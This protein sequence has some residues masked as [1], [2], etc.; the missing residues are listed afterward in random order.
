MADCNTP[1][2][3][4]CAPGPF[5]SPVCYTVP[6]SGV[7]FDGV[8]RVTIN[9]DCSVATQQILDLALA[10]VPGAVQA[11]CDPFA[12][13]TC[14]DP[15][16]ICAIVQTL[17]LQVP[18]VG[19][20][21]L[22]VT[23]GG[24]FLGVPG[25]GGGGF[26]GYGI[27]VTTACANA[28][29]VSLLVA[30]ADHVHRSALPVDDEGVLVGTRCSLNFIGA[31]VTAVDNPGLDRVDVT[32]PG[33]VFPLLAPNGSCA[34]PSY[35]FTASPD[36]GMFYT[37]TAVRVS[38]D[39]CDDFIEVGASINIH[40]SSGNITTVATLGSIAD[41][42]GTTWT[43]TAAG[44]ASLIGAGVAV[45]ATAGSIVLSAT[46][47]VH[48]VTAATSRLLINALGAWNVSAGGFGVAGQAILSNGPGV[49]PTWTTITAA[50]IGANQTIT[51]QDAGAIEVVNPS[52]LNFDD[53]FVVTPAG[54]VA[55]IDLDYGTPVATAQANAAGVATTVARSDHVHR[56]I[57]QVQDGGALTASRPTLNF[58][59]GTGITV[60]VVDN[61][62]SDRADITIASTSGVTGFAIP[63]VAADAAAATAGVATTAIRSDAKLSVATAAPPVLTVDAAAPSV[64]VATTLLRSDAKLQAAT[65]TPVATGTA[66]AAGVATTLARSDHV[67]LTSFTGMVF[68]RGAT[69]LNPAVQNTIVWRAPFACTVTNVRG[70][71]VGGTGATINARRNGTDNHLASAL[72][73]TSADTWQDGGAVQ[74][75]AYAAGDKMEIMVVTVAGSPTQVA[76]QVDL[77]RS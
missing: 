77:T 68:S 20:T 19:D 10:P 26:P 74:N 70:Y 55:E 56:T 57:V 30:R 67:H 28:A 12:Q 37:G 5:D 29:G 51:I 45:V 76:I 35:S 71:R 3:P 61:G 54:A 40:S 33:P 47:D 39:N 59:D 34:A 41:T 27:P 14:C 43:A 8:L 49:P 64:G 18:G 2:Q 44:A 73:L 52:T 72:S 36:S 13:P 38:D 66:N 48:L 25:G 31:G 60:T 69:V 15:L 1:A 21:A 75:T 24:C 42:A 58:I 6:P 32:I 50:A 63:S 9:P 22:F 46:A 4:P 11:V 17:P 62:G 53:G 16:S 65:G 23:P 7:V